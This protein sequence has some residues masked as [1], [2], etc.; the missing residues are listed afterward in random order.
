MTEKFEVGDTVQLKSGGPVMTIAD[1]DEDL[2]LSVLCMWFEGK[3]EKKS[4]FNLATLKK[5]N[6]SASIGVVGIH[7]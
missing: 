2:V 4:N 7:R 5:A 6:P 1:I 3:K